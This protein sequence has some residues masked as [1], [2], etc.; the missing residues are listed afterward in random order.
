[1]STREVR[2]GNTGIGEFERLT[3]EKAHDPPDRSDEACAGKAGPGHGLGPV[4]VVK[5]ARQN[6]CKNVFG[7]AAAL[8]LFG[9]E[10]F[11]LRC[12]QEIDFVEG[13]A[14]LLGKA[15]VRTRRRADS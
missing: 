4:E 14:L 12:L 1:M 15:H 5:Y 10:V 6:V 7:G 11:A 3:I 9:G 13:D 8:H 2:G